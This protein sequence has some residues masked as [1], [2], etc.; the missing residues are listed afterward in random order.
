MQAEIF[1]HKTSVFGTFEDFCFETW[2]V[3][4]QILFVSAFVEYNFLE[5]CQK[6]LKNLSVQVETPETIHSIFCVIK[7]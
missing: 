1:W 7:Y 5:I 4:N 6:I 3:L 2:V